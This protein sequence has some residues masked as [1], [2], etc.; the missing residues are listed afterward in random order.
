MVLFEREEF[1]QI[2]L[3]DCVEHVKALDKE[4][5]FK[6]VM[7]LQGTADN[8]TLAY[9]RRFKLIRDMMDVLKKSEMPG[10]V[11]DPLRS[12][13]S[14]GLAK[15]E[16]FEERQTRRCLGLVFQPAALIGTFEAGDHAPTT[17]PWTS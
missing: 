7:K 5:V 15:H 4:T 1:A 16:D 17:L 9:L 3:E 2:M 12:A 8:E 11:V 13:K 6:R 10:I 14:P